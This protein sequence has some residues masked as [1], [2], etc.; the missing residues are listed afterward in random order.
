MPEISTLLAH[1][2][3]FLV[4]DSIG[5]PNAQLKLRAPVFVEPIIGLGRR[6]GLYTDREVFFIFAGNV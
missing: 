1:I 6:L 2:T 5:G 3:P 4:D